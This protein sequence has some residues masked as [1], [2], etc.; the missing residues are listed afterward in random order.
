M[1]FD[2]NS[3]PKIKK[4]ESVYKV[5]WVGQDPNFLFSKTF[6][7]GKSTMDFLS[8]NVDAI[9]YKKV[10]DDKQSTVQWQ[11]IPSEGSKEMVR[12]VKLKR[13]IVEKKGL[14]SFVNADGTGNVAT[15][16]TSQYSANQK[17]LIIDTLV[18]SGALIFAGTRPEIQNKYVKWGLIGV[19]VLNAVFNIHRYNLNKNV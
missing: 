3:K 9:G 2:Q 4:P 10:K 8:K 7:D 11:I 17:A 14:S 1:I 15:V 19:A 5:E 12:S 16:T 6:V 18:V 13:K